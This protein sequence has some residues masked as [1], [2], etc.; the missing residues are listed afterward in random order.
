MVRNKP[1]ALNTRTLS[2]DHEK[3][4]SVA[5]RTAPRHAWLAFVAMLAAAPVAQAQT[6]MTFAPCANTPTQPPSGGSTIFISSIGANGQGGESSS[7]EGPGHAGDPGGPGSSLSNAVTS[8]LNAISL[9]SLGGTG[10]GGSDAGSGDPGGN[11]GG[12]VGTTG[13]AG[14]T[15]TITTS[16]PVILANPGVL[17]SAVC[18]SSAGGAGGAAGLSQNNGPRHPSGPGGAGGN[19]TVTNGNS[20]SS[21]TQAGIIASSTG[22]NGADGKSQSSG[23][24]FFAGDAGPGGIGGTVTVTNNGTIQSSTAGILAASVGGDGGTGGNT[25]NNNGTL[26]KAGN[27]GDGG[28]GNTVTV[29]NT[30]SIA[31]TNDGSPGIYAE[32]YGGL[33]GDGGG[34]G[35]G[36]KG[37]AGGPGGLVQIALGGAITVVGQDT[38]GVLVQSFGGQGSPGGSG[39]KGG[40]GG[41]GGDGGAIV[42]TGNGTITVASLAAPQSNSQG[43]LAQSIGGGGGTGGDGNST[44]IVIGGKGGIAAN[45]GPI[46]V[47]IGTQITTHG[48]RSQGILA[49]SIGGGGGNGG[50]ATSMGTFF[51]LA[52]GGSGGGGGNGNTVLVQSAGIVET[53]GEEAP[54]MLLQSIGGGGGSGGAAVSKLQSRAGTLVSIGVGIAIGGSGGGSGNGGDIDPDNAPPTNTG[55][56]FTHGS[57]STGILAQ[58]IGD[59]GGKGGTASNSAATGQKNITLAVQD[60]F[61][62]TGGGGGDG[63]SVTLQNSGF[64]LTE[65]AASR[66]LYG[67]SIGG[68]GGDGGQADQLPTAALKFDPITIVH[69]VGGKSGMG[70]NGGTVTLTNSGLIVT[71]GADGDALLAQNIGGGGGTAGAGDG[72]SQESVQVMVTLGIPVQ[73]GSGVKPAG[74][75]GGG[76]ILTN[77]DGSTNVGAILTLGDGAAGMLEQSIGGGGG[78]VGGGAGSAGDSSFSVTAA[79][80]ASAAG[81]SSILNSGPIGGPVVTVTNNGSILTFGADAPGILAQSIGGGGGL[82]GKGASTLG[83]AK[84]TGDGGNGVNT[85]GPG[86]AGVVAGGVGMLNNY[87]SLNDLLVL[88]N[89]LVGATPDPNDPLAVQLMTLAA[90]NGSS[91]NSGAASSLN[92]VLV[93]GATGGGTSGNGGFTQVTSL[94]QIATTGRMSTGILAQSVGDGGGV[95]G[96]ANTAL[97]SS[98]T[99][100][101]LT[102]GGGISTSG[103]GGP[104][105]VITGASG[106]IQTVGS[107]APGIVAQSVGGGGGLASLSGGSSALLNSLTVSFGAGSS[108]AATDGGTV[109]VTNAGGIGTA[110]HD[111][112]GIIA[113][114]IGAGGGL[115]RLLANDLETSTGQVTSAPGFTYNL[116]FGSSACGSCASGD[117]G[118][119]T[120]TH[121][122]LITTSG[123]D[124]YGILAQSIGGSGGA[125][126]GGLPNGSNFLGPALS[127]GSGHTVAVTL[128]TA[129]GASGAGSISTSGQGAV[130]ILVQS[131]GGGG[132]VAG[133]LGL[134]AQR[135]GFSRADNTMGNGG[136]VTV[137]D[138]S[139]ATLV[140]TGNNTPV[141]I[142]QSIGGGGGYI[143]NSA[144]AHDGTFGGMGR[145]GPVTVNVFSNVVAGGTS[146]PGIFAESTGSD[147]VPGDGGSNDTIAVTV[148]A[149]GVVSGGRDGKPGDAAGIYLVNGSGDA[150][151]NNVVAVQAGGTVTSLG[152][153]TGT[154]IFS[155]GNGFTQVMNAGVIIG[156]VILSSGTCTGTGCPG[157]PAMVN[158]GGGVL[159]AAAV[160]LGGGTLINAGIV[161]LRTGTGGTALN[162]N[163]HGQAGGAVVAGADF[164][165]NA[166]DVL[167]V[168]G[169]AVID[170]GSGVKVDGTKWQK[171]ATV[172]VL[173]AAGGI[174]EDPRASFGPLR[175]GYALGLTGSV[176]GNSLQ[177]Q[178]VSFLRAAAQ[179][180]STAEQ[181]V[182]NSLQAIWDSPGGAAFADGFTDLASV[183]GPSSYHVALTSLAGSALG[184]IAAAKQE[185]SERFADNL[186]NCPVFSG[187]GVAMTEDSCTWMRVVGLRTTLAS[188]SG[189]PGYGLDSATYQIGGQK[190][191]APGWF[192]GASAAYEQS[193][194]SGNSDGVKANGQSALAGI[195]LKREIGHWLLSV[196]LDGGY[197]SYSTSRVMTVGGFTGVATASPHVFHVGGSARAAYTVD[198]GIWYAEPSVTVSTVYTSMPGYSESG[199]TPF[200]L[201]VRGSGH[202]SAEVNPMIEIGSRQPAGTYGTLR[203]FAAV[204]LA[205]YVNNEWS[206]RASFEL[207]PAG[208]PGFAQTLK[209]PDVVAKTDFGVQL[210]A[211]EHIDVKLQYSAGLAPGFTSQA[212]LGRFAYT[213]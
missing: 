205:G 83:F 95:A 16:A 62:G 36:G 78:R 125:V 73:L 56:I 25:G 208:V 12:G 149:G 65:G 175:G 177:V 32:S 9:F 35:S 160:Q 120:V 147:G 159:Q 172:T 7:F 146:S 54:A 117:A 179:G 76:V 157:T 19:V 90:S 171:G 97:T 99:T 212:I 63:G 166:G 127:M 59:G 162:G 156:N 100:A 109:T 89:V 71:T 129:N 108:G 121:T 2:H 84:S 163:Y 155:T 47:N 196:V 137:T 134:T 118:P 46:S 174:T 213:F 96:V 6:A 195:M 45:G 126:L 55:I 167:T 91:G 139:S 133:D 3:Q 115:V 103:S 173:T 132:G 33:G 180:L 1:V 107:L 23:V 52:I 119:V 85:A 143:T 94:G 200:N 57:D 28:A 150:G 24:F 148:F 92:V 186:I 37:G 49:Q 21:P 86:L 203:V 197:G 13:G 164:S 112:P 105:Q 38:E 14:G 194:L 193:W 34:V 58:S 122:G 39:A 145:G 11:N 151:I 104:V 22:A 88:A 10:G 66:G 168:D 44:F 130:A 182:A 185:A 5:S 60:A 20:I 131:I 61:G 138:N 106:N 209:L 30:G 210:Y 53:N 42:F 102:L 142:A 188:S 123:N 187:S 43:I 69:D 202:T 207:A 29:T 101:A 87:S 161:D 198:L 136:T 192:V 189:A 68:G 77:N 82:F 141:I 80:G 75:N 64:I 111:S 70:G 74:G 79:L 183:D 184:G 27:G 181:G 124:A 165:R 128:G 116:K 190:E 140:T 199:S 152:G 176:V 67:Q 40:A 114:S 170:A 98:S 18:A 31:T 158:L 17:N 206:S 41:T 191:V 48:E 169:T 144:G 110:S 8:A 50:N 154:A 211:H 113:Q 204:G 135:S 153:T 201:A 72:A 93:L 4:H 81:G 15:V 178:P 51:S 26:F